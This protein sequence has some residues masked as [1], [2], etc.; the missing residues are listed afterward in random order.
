MLQAL[1][2]VAKFT[3]WSGPF[4][5]DA[6]YIFASVLFLFFFASRCN[7]GFPI[8]CF[9]SSA[10]AD[11]MDGDTSEE[12]AALKQEIAQL[13]AVNRKLLEQATLPS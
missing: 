5:V 9:Q 13:K 12:M 2:E 7:P 6:K 8:H 11:Q 3:F 4:L 1:F 10:S